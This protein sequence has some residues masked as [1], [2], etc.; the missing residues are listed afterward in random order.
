VQKQSLSLSLSV[1]VCVCADPSRRRSSNTML[2]ALLRRCTEGTTRGLRAGAADHLAALRYR[3]GPVRVMTRNVA[4]GLM[5]IG[6]SA[7][8]LSPSLSLS[9]SLS[10]SVSWVSLATDCNVFVCMCV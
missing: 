1:C 7:V 9:L 6:P 10:L 5:S 4:H 8:S 2:S 3:R